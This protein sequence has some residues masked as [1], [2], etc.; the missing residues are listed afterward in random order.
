MAEHRSGPRA[1]PQPAPVLGP[2]RPKERIETIDILRGFALFG[3]ILV[4][5]WAFQSFY[6]L[7]WRIEYAEVWTGTADH[8]A[9]WFIAF[10][11][12]ERFFRLYSF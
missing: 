5:T 12:E 3:V 8:I 11:A 4:N 7:P 10:F 6:I 2:V 9:M 1:T